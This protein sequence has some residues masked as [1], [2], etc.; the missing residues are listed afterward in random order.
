MQHAREW[1]AGETCRRT[2]DYFVDNYGEATPTHGR[3]PVTRSS[4]TRASCGSSA[5]PT[6]TATSTRSRPA[7]ACGARTWPTT[8]ATACSASRATAS[9]R[10]ATSPTN[11]GRDDEGSSRRPAVGD[12]PRP[13]PDSEPETKAMQEP[14]G[15]RRLRVPEER[16][17]GGRAA[18]VSAGLP[19]VHADA[20]QRHLRGAGRRRR[21][22]G[23]RRQGFNED[24][25]WEITGNRF[26]PDLS[27]SSTSPTATRSTTRTT[28]RHPRLHARGHRAATIPNVSG[29]E[30]QDDEADDRGGVPAPPAVRR[31][32][33]RESADDPANADVAPGQHRRRTSTSTTFADSYG[34]P[35]PVQVDGQALAR[36][37]QAALPRSTAARCRPAP[38]TRVRRAASATTRSRASTTTACAARSR[39]PSP[40][41]EVEVW[42]EG[43]GKSLVALHLQGARRRPAPRC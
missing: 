40:G 6:R 41:D 39:A 9:T 18:A 33:S 32:T 28:P 16:P 37:R 13:G 3:D 35:Q 43:G 21:R 4:S 22:P 36:R 27:P 5:S 17:H 42:F 1:L 7:T 24:D 20:G 29:F 31:S 2:L 15:P 11:W 10:T 14:L 12:L 23:D 38:T 25:E 26:D 8:T 34:D 30:F 19:A